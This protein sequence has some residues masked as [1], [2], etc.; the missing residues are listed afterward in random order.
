MDKQLFDEA[1]SVYYEFVV[2]EKNPR[3]EYVKTKKKRWTVSI[4]EK[5]ET[6]FE[7]I[8][9]RPEKTPK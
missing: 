7:L 1:I 3:G 2:T 5:R 9:G 4:Y 8:Y 6:T